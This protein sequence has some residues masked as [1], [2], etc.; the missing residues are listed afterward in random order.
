MKEAILKMENN[1]LLFVFL[2]PHSNNSNKLKDIAL[3]CGIPHVQ[4]IESVLD[5]DCSALKQ[6][7]RIAVTAGASTPTYLTDQVVDYLK[8]YSL[9]SNHRILDID[10]GKI[11]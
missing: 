7:D 9:D 2:D 3:K 6:T 1:Y 4:L 10:I 11:L 5:L 8:A